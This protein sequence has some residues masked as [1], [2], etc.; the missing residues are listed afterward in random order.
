[1]F[2]TKRKSK[3][4]AAQRRLPHDKDLEPSEWRWD[5]LRRI[6]RVDGYRRESSI[7]RRLPDR[8]NWIESARNRFRASG[9]DALWPPTILRIARET[10]NPIFRKP[11]LF[12]RHLGRYVQIVAW[13]KRS[14]PAIA[15]PIRLSESTPPKKRKLIPKKWI[16][17]F[18][19]PIMLSLRG[20]IGSG[21]PRR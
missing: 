2:V 11:T 17:G 12:L 14:S 13:P 18:S 15:K 19:L 21:Q 4:V 8:A 16:V 1:M 7:S 10:N 20:R 6:N 3:R 5:A 9:E